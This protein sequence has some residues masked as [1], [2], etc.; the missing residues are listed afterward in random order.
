MTFSSLSS[1]TP[2]MHWHLIYYHQDQW[3]LLHCAFNSNWASALCLATCIP[4]GHSSSMPALDYDLHH[5]H[6]CTETPH[7]NVVSQHALQMLFISA[8]KHTEPV[9]TIQ[10]KRYPCLTI[11][12]KIDSSGPRFGFGQDV[13]KDVRKVTV[14]MQNTGSL[15]CS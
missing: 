8:T 10:P 13:I 9:W 1:G 3:V 14:I 4:A 6:I 11:H 2:Q 12:F 7:T 15:E 5:T